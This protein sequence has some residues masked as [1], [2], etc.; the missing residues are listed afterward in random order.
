MTFVKLE[1]RATSGVTTSGVSISF[2]GSKRAPGRPACIIG[3]KQQFLAAAQ[4]GDGMTFDVAIGEGDDIGEIRVTP[5]PK[6]V[7]TARKVFDARVLDIGHVAQFG[8]R[9]HKCRSA[10][11]RV[12]E[13][14]AIITLP[15]V[16][17]DSDAGET[18][19]RIAAPKPAK[20]TAPA[21]KVA[22]PLP[23]RPAVPG[24]PDNPRYIQF[25]GFGLTVHLI[26][27][28][29]AVV[30][31]G[32]VVAV[33]PRGARLVAILAKVTPN[34]IGDAHLIGKLWDKAPPS[35]AASLEMVIADLKSLKKIGIEIRTQK[36]IGRQ[37][38]VVD[39]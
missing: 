12:V 18:G 3:L 34:C 22:V 25:D 15:E 24:L 1:R 27:G 6:G 39:K 4:F 30:R 11:V 17:P 14:A 23:K 28:E 7:F 20:V 26:A 31:N 29:E 21:E 38:V 33:S 5:S 36:G 19:E 2:R 8:K 37:L 13:G 35:G 9:K 16:E 32:E 10:I